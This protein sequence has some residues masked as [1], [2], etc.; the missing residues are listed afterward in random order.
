M[1]NNPR[2]ISNPVHISRI[3]LSLFEILGV[4]QQPDAPDDENPDT[5]KNEKKQY[6]DIR[7]Q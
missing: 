4:E 1:A 3:V 6:P 2:R 7:Q 5:P